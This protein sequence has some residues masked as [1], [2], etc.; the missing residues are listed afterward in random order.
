[1]YQPRRQSVRWVLLFLL[2]ASVHSLAA[3][4]GTAPLTL[5]ADDAV[6][7]ALENNLAL[8][9]AR[10]LPALA[11][12]DVYAARGSWAPRFISRTTGS[13]RETPPASAFDQPSVFNRQLTVQAGV[14][15]RLAW[16]TSY[17]VSWDGGRLTTNNPLARYLPQLATA[18]TAS[19]TQPLLRGFRYD[20]VRAAH[21]AG[22]RGVDVAEAQVDSAVA[23]TTRQV[24][25]AYWAW[26][27]ARDFLQVQRDSLAYAQ[28]LL[29]GNRE[30]VRVGSIAGAD[31]IEAEAEVARRSE[32]ILIAANQVVDTEDQ[33]RV[34][35]F[36]PRD[37][38][39]A[40]P[41]EPA[42]GLDE[43]GAVA[44]VGEAGADQLSL[45]ARRDLRVLSTALAIDD[46]AVRQ[47]ANNRL[48]DL[49]L[50]ADYAMQATAGTEL[51]RAQGFTGPVT[52]RLDR[53][54]SAA[55]S[56]LATSRFPSWTVAVAV[57]YPLGTDQADAD[58]AR[59]S[60]RRRQDQI[61]FEAA[62]QQAALEMRVAQRAVAVN[63]QRLDTTAT[64]VALSAQR[65]DNE[66]RKF[67]AGLST[68]FF[69][70]QA[71][72]DLAQTREQ[73]LRSMLDYRWSL[74]DLEAV[75]V[76]PVSK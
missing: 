66:E 8:D 41:L 15:Q 64:A 69:V 14:A 57:S 67:L 26:L 13:N 45:E 38:R 17:D 36:T 44:S 53:S 5:T 54:F 50:R 43:L 3:Q 76:I 21:D 35:I 52:G 71:Q 60:V 12:Q 39:F 11:V 42:R 75:Q 33:L 31:V 30:R 34:I 63:R 7:F 18:A 61:A 25:R 73:Q 24:R 19:V 48:P 58:A 65:L 37:P 6:R 72:R 2:A 9:S 28:A 46:I 40:R 1:M 49:A 16:G 23:T 59:A 68:S 56:D 20:A 32:A 55:L 51:L 62:E 27:Y 74:V 4:E 29:D 47:A 22:L 70:F 10:L